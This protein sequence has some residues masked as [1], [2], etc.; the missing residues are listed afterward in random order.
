MIDRHFGNKINEKVAAKYDKSVAHAEPIIPNF[1]IS[2][3]FSKIFKIH[4]MK[5]R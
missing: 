5:V 3:R 2:K 1:G 4:P